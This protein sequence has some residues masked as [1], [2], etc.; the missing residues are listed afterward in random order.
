MVFIFVRLNV[1]KFYNFAELNLRFCRTSTSLKIKHIPPIKWNASTWQDLIDL[2]DI[3]F[4]EPATTQHLSD[5]EIFSLTQK[6][7]LC[8]IPD[9][10]SHLQ[11]VERSVKL[12]SDASHTIYGY[13]NGYKSIL[14]KILSRKPHQEFS[15]KGHYYQTYDNLYL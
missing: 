3:E 11:S 9:L 7:S 12:V 1:L 13:E 15:S 10:P 4:Q 8:K 6:D 14:T 2:T 5:V